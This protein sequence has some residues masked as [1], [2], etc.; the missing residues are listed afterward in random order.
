[1][2]GYNKNEAIGLFLLSAVLLA[3]L[4]LIGDKILGERK[5]RDSVGGEIADVS[6]CSINGMCIIKLENGTQARA[7]FPVA[8]T[9]LSKEHCEN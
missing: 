5:C 2:N 1:M 3:G 8:G 9:K 6:R 7:Y 4:L